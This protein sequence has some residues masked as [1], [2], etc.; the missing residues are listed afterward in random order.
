MKGGRGGRKSED[1]SQPSTI[2]STEQKREKRRVRRERGG[3]LPLRFVT[4]ILLI[5]RDLFNG[6]GKKIEG[7]R[8]GALNYCHD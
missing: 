6:R 7:R 4:S 5:S 3:V 1:K 8:G 2:L